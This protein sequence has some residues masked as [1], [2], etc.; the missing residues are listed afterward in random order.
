[1]LNNDAQVEV[2]A[3]VV[4]AKVGVARPKPKLS[5]VRSS[6]QR[7]M[8][9]ASRKNRLCVEMHV[10]VRMG[11]RHHW[12]CIDHVAVVS[13]SGTPKS[14]NSDVQPDWVVTPDPAAD[15]GGGRGVGEGRGADQEG[16]GAVA[17]GPG[18]SQL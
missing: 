11:G 1:M 6:A 18:K 9:P 8:F 13:R 12:T 3:A 4:A 2:A 7:Y 16:A 14:S 17:R 15:A 10:R 5:P